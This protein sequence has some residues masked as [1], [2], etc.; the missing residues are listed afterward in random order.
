MAKVI[1]RP[2]DVQIDSNLRG[3]FKQLGVAHSW[4]LLQMLARASSTVGCISQ[5]LG[6]AESEISR[7]LKHLRELGLVD[8]V[9]MKKLHFYALSRQVQCVEQHGMIELY[10]PWEGSWTLVIQLDQP[11][12]SLNGKH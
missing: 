10:I 1:V 6:L 11:P 12:F 2:L 5:Q 3:L 9:T 7:S 4:E 8:F